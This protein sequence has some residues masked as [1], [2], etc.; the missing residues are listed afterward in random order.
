MIPVLLI[1]IPL[2][3]GLAAFFIKQEKGVR[4]LALLSALVTLALSLLAVTIWKNS[5]HLAGKYE[6]MQS[7]G[8]SF[9]VRLDGMGQVLCLLTALA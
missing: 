1:V 3:T 2:V 8:S 6:W 5:P 7:L 4:S 9:S